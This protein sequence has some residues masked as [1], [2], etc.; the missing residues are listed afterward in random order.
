MSIFYFHCIVDFAL[1]MVKKKELLIFQVLV[2]QKKPVG[3]VLGR[4]HRV[5]IRVLKKIQP[6]GFQS[7]PVRVQK[8]LGPTGSSPGSKKQIFMQDFDNENSILWCTVDKKIN[9]GTSSVSNKPNRVDSGS[10]RTFKKLGRFGS[11]KK[12]NRSHP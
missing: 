8:F 5:G 2:N 7:R 11:K 12:T 10:V 9:N 4:A 1:E 6:T 3:L